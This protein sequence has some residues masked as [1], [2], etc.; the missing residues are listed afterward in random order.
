MGVSNAEEMMQEEWHVGRILVVF[1][2]FT[3][4]IFSG[5][6]FFVK[7]TAGTVGNSVVKPKAVSLTN[8]K[9]SN[10]IPIKPQQTEEHKTEPEYI[11]RALLATEIKNREPLGLLHSP[12]KVMSGARIN[13]SL[14]TEIRSKKGAVFFHQ[15][16]H[17]DRTV[18][19]RRIKVAGIR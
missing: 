9:E 15:W 13:V 17:K 3:V 1:S 18:F 8:R 7:E 4:L 12:V 5:Y 2:I 19:T 14:F 10:A 16:R 11:A 6:W